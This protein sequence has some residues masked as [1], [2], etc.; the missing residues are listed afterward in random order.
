[1]RHDIDDV[2]DVGLQVLLPRDL[3]AAPEHEAG[4]AIELHPRARRVRRP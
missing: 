4:K 1:M 2:A 3:R